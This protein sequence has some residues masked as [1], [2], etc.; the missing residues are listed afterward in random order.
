MSEKKTCET[1]AHIEVCS[2]CHPQL[3]VCDSYEQKERHGQW[4]DRYG[5]K[6][7]NSLYECSECKIEALYK[8]EVDTLGHKQMTQALTDICPYCGA[9]MNKEE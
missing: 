4:I 8:I 5:G 2:C 9:K 3:P 6:Y 1:C 7:A